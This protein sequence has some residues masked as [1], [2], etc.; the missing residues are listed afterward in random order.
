MEYSLWDIL[1]WIANLHPV[2]SLFTVAPLT[3]DHSF[4]SKR[5]LAGKGGLSDL[6]QTFL[7]QISPPSS[8]RWRLCCTCS[9]RTVRLTLRRLCSAMSWLSPRSALGWGWYTGLH[10]VS[11]SLFFF[12]FFFRKKSCLTPIDNLSVMADPPTWLSTLYDGAFSYT[13]ALD[14]TYALMPLLKASLVGFSLPKWY[15]F[16]SCRL[17]LGI[18]ISICKLLPNSS[19]WLQARWGDSFSLQPPL[20]AAPFPYKIHETTR[21]N[22]LTAI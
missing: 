16:T 3:E 2:K 1:G 19:L 17:I 10:E 9:P 22:F 11:E 14:Q 15:L 21:T 12:L 7:T 20:S 18:Q 13:S 8:I 6:L 5:F 4:A